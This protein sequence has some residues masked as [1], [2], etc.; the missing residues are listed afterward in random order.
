MVI[1]IKNSHFLF[2]VAQFRPSGYK[3][4]GRGFVGGDRTFK[5]SEK[6][7]SGEW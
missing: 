5:W 2:Q 7:R 1:R 3:T 4:T 6:V